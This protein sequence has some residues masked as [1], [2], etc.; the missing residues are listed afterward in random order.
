MAPPKK[1][2]LAERFW[3]YVKKTQE[4]WIWTGPLSC[5]GYGVLSIGHRGQ[6]KAHRLSWEIHNGPVPKGLCVLHKCDVRDCVNPYHLWLGTKGENTLDMVAKG[7]NAVSFG[8]KNGC[9]NLKEDDIP[10]IRYARSCGDSYADIGRKYG[11]TGCMIRRII[12][13]LAWSQVEGGK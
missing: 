8:S 3:S 5:Y 1:G 9:S 13:G 10:R 6:V 7:R 2:T 4:C 12:T 11:V